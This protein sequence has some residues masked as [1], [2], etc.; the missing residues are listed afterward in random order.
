VA[1][2]P[3]RTS[4]R[5]NARNGTTNEDGPPTRANDGRA[6]EQGPPER[7]DDDRFDGTLENEVGDGEE[8]SDDGERSP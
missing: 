1:T 8:T 5:Q 2:T 7:A 4:T 6:D 3:S